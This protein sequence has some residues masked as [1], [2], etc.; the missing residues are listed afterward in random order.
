MSAFEQL[1]DINN[2]AVHHFECMQLTEAKTLFRKAIDFVYTILADEPS[3]EQRTNSSRN[4]AASSLAGPIH[5]GWSKASQTKTRGPKNDVYIFTRTARIQALPYE[6]SLTRVYLAAV[7]YNLAVTVHLEAAQK[8][9]STHFKAACRLY[10][11]SFNM[12][13]RTGYSKAGSDFDLMMVSTLNNSGAI[14]YSELSRYKD[15]KRCFSAVSKLLS[16][17]PFNTTV[18]LN[19]GE[20]AELLMNL[21]VQSVSAAPAA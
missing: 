20:V 6:S 15:A 7:L 1:A 2:A 16:A 10:D 9:S 3:S 13:K 18:V 8:S 11:M 4:A 17:R 5:A 14:F 12:L 21:Y 19:D